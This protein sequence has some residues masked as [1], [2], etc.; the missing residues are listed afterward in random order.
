[1]SIP[2]KPAPK[3]AAKADSI[4]QAY[5]LPTVSTFKPK[6]GRLYA[7]RAGGLYRFGKDGEVVASMT[8]IEAMDEEF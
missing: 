5:V 6:P 7:S 4:E 8:P 2:E 1:M 3:P